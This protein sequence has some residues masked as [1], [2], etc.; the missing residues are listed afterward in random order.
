MAQLQREGGAA[1]R[2]A[3][4][5]GDPL[6][7]DM[8]ALAEGYESLLGRTRFE[9]SFSEEGLTVDNVQTFR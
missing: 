9:L 3:A 6:A 7:N 5:Q 1:Y 8:N 4:D 2:N